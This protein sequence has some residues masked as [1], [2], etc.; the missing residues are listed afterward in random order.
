MVNTDNRDVEAQARAWAVVGASAVGL[1]LHFGSLLVNTFGIFLKPLGE[2]FDWTRGEISLAFTLGSLSALASMPVV[3]LLTDRIGARKLILFSMTLFGA[4]FGS[5]AL[6][7]FHLWHL[8]L[9]FILMG[10]LGPGTS[11]V[12]HASLLTRWFDRRRGLALGLAM[13]GTGLGGIVWPPAA[14]A[15][16]DAFGWQIS[17][18]LLGA[19][20]LGVGVLVM[21][22]FLKEPETDT[23]GAR[24]ATAAATGLNRSEALGGE[25]FWILTAAFFIASASVQAC[26]IHLAPMLSD[27]GMTAASAAGAVSIFGA[28]SLTARVST[29]YLLDRFFAPRVA[30]YAFIAIAVGLLVLVAGAKG[31]TAYAAALLAG[32]G[33]GAETATAPYLVSRYFGLRAFGELYSYL[34]LTVPLGGVVGPALAGLGFDRTGSYGIPLMVCAAAMLLATVLLL[35]LRSYPTFTVLQKENA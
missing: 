24:Q 9:L 16:I 15:L 11:A 10:L 20:V 1:F 18:A 12:P 29:G 3:G 5:L 13:G 6:L 30:R 27:R 22:V 34:F 21:V 26:Q 7:T 35:R 25:V 19:L 31:T 14:Q 33:Y 32:L 17:Y 23:A 28:A 8:Y 2:H 4:I